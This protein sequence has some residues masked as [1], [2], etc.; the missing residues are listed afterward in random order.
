MSIII[1]IITIEFYI[2]IIIIIRHELRLARPVST[3]F[4]SLLKG[5]VAV[6]FS[7]NFGEFIMYFLI[8]PNVTAALYQ[9]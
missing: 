2:I 5:P 8:P 7:I 6:Y 9:K 3:S 1:I 4:N